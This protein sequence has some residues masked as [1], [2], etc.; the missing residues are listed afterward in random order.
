MKKVKYG[1]NFLVNKEIAQKIVDS[2]N[3]SAGDNIL[4][5][6]SGEGILTELIGGK[7]KSL[8]ILEIDPFYISYLKGKLSIGKNLSKA[9]INKI[10]FVNIDALKFDFINFAGS[11]N[12][13]LRVISNLPYE[14]SSPIM[15]K[16]IKEKGVFSDLTLM[17]QKEF[18]QRISAKEND[19]QRG[20]LS[21]IVQANFDT[22]C[23]FDVSKTEFNPMPDVD[24][25]VLRLIPKL[26]S[27]CD[28]IWAQSPPFFN[29]FVHQI[30]KFRRKML[31]N[32]IY[33]SFLSI[34]PDAKEKVFKEAGIDLARR[35][36]TLS[37]TEFIM[38]A[39]SYNDYLGMKV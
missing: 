9:G 22:N 6:G 20:A 35:P 2:C 7:T 1:Q 13:K 14:I 31:K 3:F 27:D 16:F 11:L 37:V 18:A 12:S 15:E 33:S 23:L 8:T 36:Q 17:F 39:K 19:P 34:P 25:S 10:N 24:S 21:V 30:F 5:I 32:S 38:V 4:E 28:L 29:Y 26:S